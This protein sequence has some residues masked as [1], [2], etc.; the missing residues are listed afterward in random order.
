[1]SG[2]ILSWGLNFMAK[3]SPSERARQAWREKLC[4]GEHPGKGREVLLKRVV[5]GGRV[6]ARPNRKSLAILRYCAHRRRM[7]LKQGVRP[8]GF[9]RLSDAIEAILAK[10]E[11]RAERLPSVRL[12]NRQRLERALARIADCRHFVVTTEW[13]TVALRRWPGVRNSTGIDPLTLQPWANRA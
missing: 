12:W 11:G 3:L 4:R 8:I 2:S 13:S 9:S 5:R 6:F 7:C 1:M 10:R